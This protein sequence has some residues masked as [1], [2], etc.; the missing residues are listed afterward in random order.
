MVTNTDIAKTGNKNRG[1]MTESAGEK[2]GE[3]GHA[4]VEFFPLIFFLS[5]L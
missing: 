3:S 5:L 1:M 2:K 4:P